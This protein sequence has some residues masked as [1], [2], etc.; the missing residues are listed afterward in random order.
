M[1]TVIRMVGCT[2]I[3]AIGTFSLWAEADQWA[4]ADGWK[5]GDYVIVAIDL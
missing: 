5:P 1:Y 4:K 3:R 2:P